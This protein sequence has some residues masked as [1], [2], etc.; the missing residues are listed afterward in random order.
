MVYLDYRPGAKL[1]G[2]CMFGYG[3]I[4]TIVII[5]LIVWIVR[6]FV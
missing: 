5:C 1:Y 6:K 3:L 4:G 2:G